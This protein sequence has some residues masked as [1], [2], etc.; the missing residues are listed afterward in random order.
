MLHHIGTQVVADQVRVPGGGGQQPLH[1]I[2]GALPG[3]LGQLPAVLATRV[4]QQPTQV[5]QHPPTRFRPREPTR[6]PGV[7]RHQPRCPRPHFLDVCRLVGLRHGSSHPPWRSALPAP[8]PAGGRE[9]YLI[10][11]AAGVLGGADAGRAVVTVS[12]TSASVRRLVSGGSVQCPRVP[13][14]RPVS[15]VRCGRL[16]VQV[17]GV[18]CPCVPAVAVSDRSEVVGRRWGRQPYG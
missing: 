4:A 12:A 17:S 18:R 9:P 16:S 3:V 13:V 14:H 8:C 11:S 1:P 15:R 6:D 10:P 7:Q 2:R 5:R